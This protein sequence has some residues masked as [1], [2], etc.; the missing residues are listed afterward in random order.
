METRKQEL[1]AEYDENLKR[2]KP[3]YPSMEKLQEQIDDIEQKLS[4]AF[5]AILASAGKSAVA[6]AKQEAKLRARV[7]DIKEKVLSLQDQNTD[8]QTLKRDVSANRQLYEVLLQRMK[9]VDL[10]AGIS[11]NNIAVIDKAEVPRYPYKPNLSRN[12]K[13][14]LMLGLFG[15]CLIAFV[16]EKFDDTLKTGEE[17]EKH[18][19]LPLLGVTPDIS[20]EEALGEEEIALLTYRVPN[21][22][23]AEAYRSIRTGL[24]FSTHDGTPKILHFTSSG[25]VEGKTTSA[26]GVATAFVQAGN[27]V[28]LIDGDMRNP[29]LHRLFGLTHNQP[30]LSSYL[31]GDRKPYEVTYSTEIEKVFVIPAGPSPANPVELLSGS[32]MLELLNIALDRFDYI[33]IDS[34]PVV[35][36]ADALVLSNLAHATV[37]IAASGN[38]RRSI[39]DGSIKRLRSARATLVGTILTRMDRETRYG[40]YSYSYNYDYS[41]GTKTPRALDNPSV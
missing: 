32:K 14:A 28:L 34:P 31:T 29:S 7:A 35:G 2:L 25:P 19:G 16:F 11:T 37:F 24:F 23:L 8:Y 18:L 22:I 17:L 30:G 27:V 21:S 5:Q 15:G 13:I 36:L 4:D 1:Q 26:I 20:R 9:E 6:Y 3:G 39:V 41:Y 12:L 38:L 40:Y 33:I 10:I